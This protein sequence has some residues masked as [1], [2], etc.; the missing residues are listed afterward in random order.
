MIAYTP[1]DAAKVAAV[2]VAMVKD[3]IRRRVL[4]ARDAEGEPIV[5]HSD[6]SAWVDTLPALGSLSA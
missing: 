6:L 5:L 4:P 2:P 3:A 1:Q